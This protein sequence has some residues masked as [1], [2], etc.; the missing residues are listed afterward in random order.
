MPKPLSF[1]RDADPARDPA[2]DGPRFAK[3]RPAPASA[4]VDLS[5]PRLI[6]PEPVDNNDGR[7]RG[8]LRRGASLL[9][10]SP[11]VWSLRSGA[12]FRLPAGDEWRKVRARCECGGPAEWN[13]AGL[14][15]P[16]CDACMNGAVESLNI[17]DNNDPK[18]AA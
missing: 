11:V 6:D 3:P 2:Y 17:L 8:K 14:E 10:A 12:Q 15:W 1:V 5:D 4:A 7:G 18:E 13:C 16:V 9:R